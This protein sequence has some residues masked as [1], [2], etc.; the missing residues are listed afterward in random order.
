MRKDPDPVV[1]LA[2]SDWHLC[3]NRPIA[4]ADSN[5][6][7]V[8]ERSL[9]ELGEL[10]SKYRVP[11][12]IA[13]DL[14]D[15]WN[16]CPE[17]INFALKYLPF[18]TYAVPGQHDLPFHNYAD[19]RKSAFGSLVYADRLQLLEPSKTQ[20]IGQSIS[21]RVTGFPW[22]SEITDPESDPDETRQRDA[23]NIAV[24]HAY[25]WSSRHDCYDYN[26]VPDHRRSGAYAKVLNGYDVAI[27][28][29]NHI[30]FVVDQLRNKSMTNLINCGTFMRR[31]LNEQKT[32]PAIGLIHQSGR[33]ELHH[34]DVSRDKFE[35]PKILG[36]QL[37]EAFDARVLVKLLR[38]MGASS[39]FDFER[40]VRNVADQ[41]EIDIEVRNEILCALE[42]SHAG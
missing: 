18:N 6:Y 35:D 40:L 3:H 42:K 4:R 27:F 41:R 26:M 8:M 20:T 31:H 9:V 11:T 21:I 19:W 2:T 12:L 5:W 25:V 28:G 23:L 15:K 16:S 32:R 22:G 29:D 37:Q 13:G 14:F 17:L 7:E 33:I 38:T 34:L 39:T 36:S 24:I 10:S 1:A 30:P